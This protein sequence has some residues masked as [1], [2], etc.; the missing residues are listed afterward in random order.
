MKK[1]EREES[2]DIARR[3]IRAYRRDESEHDRSTDL[4]KIATHDE[5]QQSD[6]VN[7]DTHV[8]VRDEGRRANVELL[9]RLV[10]AEF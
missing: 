6:A 4:F 3:L 9:C 1:A 5:R 10:R 8:V 2:D 7:L